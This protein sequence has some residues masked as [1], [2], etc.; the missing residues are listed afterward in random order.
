MFSLLRV[1]SKFELLPGINLLQ[2]TDGVV[3]SLAIVYGINNSHEKLQIR[4]ANI[5][6]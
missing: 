4:Y 6:V 3:N 2:L 5:R 1:V